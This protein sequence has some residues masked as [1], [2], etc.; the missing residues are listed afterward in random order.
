MNATL[1]EK[2]TLLELLEDNENISRHFLLEDSWEKLENLT[3]RQ[4]KYFLHLL[5]VKKYSKLNNLLTQ[6]GFQQYE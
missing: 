3:S 1:N 2:T 4:Y 5:F 6:F